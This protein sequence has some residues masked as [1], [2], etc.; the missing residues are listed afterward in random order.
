MFVCVSMCSKVKISSFHTKPG[1]FWVFLN[2]Q[3]TRTH[4]TLGAEVVTTPQQGRAGP[5]PAPTA[6]PWR[7]WLMEQEAMTLSRSWQALE[8]PAPWCW[9]QI[10]RKGWR[11]ETEWVKAVPWAGECCFHVYMSVHWTLAAP[12]ITGEQIQTIGATP[13]QPWENSRWQVCTLLSEKPAPKHL[14]PLWVVSSESLWK[15]TGSDIA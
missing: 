11:R 15:K 5:V 7:T 2:K 10:L 14:I 4:P 8:C 9:G 12:G 1:H 3:Q 6:G 13:K